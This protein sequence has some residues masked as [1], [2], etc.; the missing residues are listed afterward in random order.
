[1]EI[2]SRLIVIAFGIWMIGVSGIIYTRPE[3][4]LTSLRK[5]ASTNL[6]NY[7]ELGLRL[8]VGLGVHRFGAAHQFSAIAKICRYVF[9]GHRDYFNPH[10]ARV[11]S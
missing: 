7:T 5:F 3:F 6:I 2:A 9:S 8:L 1:M 10:P 11:A 4:A